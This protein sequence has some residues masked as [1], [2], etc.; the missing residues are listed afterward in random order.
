MNS[1][2]NGT[3]LHMKTTL[4][5]VEGIHDEM[6]LK[7]F[8]PHIQTI[9]VGGSAI[10]RDSLEFLKQYQDTF[11]IVLLLDPDYPGNKIRQTLEQELNEVQHIFVEIDKARYKKKVGIEHMKKEDLDKALNHRLSKRKEQSISKREFIELDLQGSE[12]STQKRNKLAKTLHL[13]IVNAK[14]MYKRL[15]MI[16]ITKREI[17]DLL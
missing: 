15:N 16:G 1:A 11:D 6:H 7:N 4:F 2:K 10:N 13:G 14:T 12:A 8:Y 5:V 9:S 3:F 17:E